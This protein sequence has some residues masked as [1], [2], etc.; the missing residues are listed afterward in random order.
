MNTSVP[1]A[2][3]LG[4]FGIEP[5]WSR[6]VDVPSHDGAT[7]RWHVLDR[8]GTHEKALTILCLHGNPTW[9]Y[10]WSRVLNETNQ[11]HRIIAP[12]HLSMG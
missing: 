11:E 7:H 12:D 10:L 4:A 6:T 8:P 9:S 2:A 1:S 3:E 5:T